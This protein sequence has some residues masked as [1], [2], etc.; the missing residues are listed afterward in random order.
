MVIR[1]HSKFNIEEVTMIQVVTSQIIIITEDI[2]FNLAIEKLFIQ[3][4][5]IFN[6]RIIYVPTLI[7]FNYLRSKIICLFVLLCKFI[8]F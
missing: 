8:V 7:K 4:N 5:N 3:T 2:L 1:N 6:I